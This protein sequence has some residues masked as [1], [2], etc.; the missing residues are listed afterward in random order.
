MGG[1][2]TSEEELCQSV[3]LLIHYF[4]LT[5]TLWLTISSSII[6]HK[7]VN[8][9][10]KP[11]R[12]INPYV[13][14]PEEEVYIGVGDGKKYKKPMTRFYLVGW[15]VPLIICGITGGASLSQYSSSSWCFLSLPPA[16]GA[17]LIPIV[18]SFLIHFFFLFAILTF[19]PNR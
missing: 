17:I 5:S 9:M 4:T 19:S 14:T 11:I 6:Y 15:G 16:A 12:H 18:I 1:E 3:G 2:L 7:L 10:D 8:P 13:V